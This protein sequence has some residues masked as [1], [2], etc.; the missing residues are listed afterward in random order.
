M[1]AGLKRKLEVA[2]A[3]GK[4]SSTAGSSK[5]KGAVAQQEQE[6]AASSEDEDESRTRS[7]AKK[8]KVVDPFANKLGR[9]AKKANKKASEVKP[10]IKQQQPNA[11]AHSRKKGGNG[12]DDDDDSDSDDYEPFKPAI[13]PM[14]TPVTTVTKSPAKT[15]TAPVNSIR[16]IAISSEDVKKAK[17]LAKKQ[18]RK[19]RRQH[20]A[21]ALTAVSAV[22]Q[23]T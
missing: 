20:E 18:K 2:R 17:R 11:P 6:Q 16:P 8:Q 19:E 12:N 13:R 9:K 7:V 1:S 14:Q 22:Q 15:A 21:A 5:G 4:A 3:E 23:T 10:V